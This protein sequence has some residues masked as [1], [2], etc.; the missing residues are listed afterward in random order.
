L[1]LY[2]LIFLKIWGILDSL[3]QIWDAQLIDPIFF[4]LIHTDRWQ[5]RLKENRK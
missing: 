1:G 2:Y 4:G 5:K 3:R